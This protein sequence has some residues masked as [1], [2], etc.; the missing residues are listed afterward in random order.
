MR[1]AHIHFIFAA[2]G[3][4]RLVTELFDRQDK[5]V[6]DDAVFA[7]K[8][9]LIANFLPLKGDPKAQYEVIYNFK[10]GRK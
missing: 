4:K 10:L 7:V 2:S 6:N 1:P 3:Y 5:H 8:E 9:N